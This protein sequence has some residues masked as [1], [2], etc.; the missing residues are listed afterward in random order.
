MSIYLWHS[1]PCKPNSV[2][3]NKLRTQQYRTSGDSVTCLLPSFLLSPSGGCS[4]P[5]SS[6]LSFSSP[7]CCWCCSRWPRSS[8]GL[9]LHC[10]TSAAGSTKTTGPATFSHSLPSSSTLVW[11]PLTWWGTE[12]HSFSRCFAPI[13]IKGKTQGFF[14]IMWMFVTVNHFV[15]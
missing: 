2:N 8:S 10:S 7:T 1:V 15:Q 11:R 9:Q 4:L 14:K 6:F 13:N 5:S 12:Q 3:K